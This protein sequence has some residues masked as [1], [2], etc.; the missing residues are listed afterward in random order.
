MARAKLRNP[1]SN[2][3]RTYLDRSRNEGLVLEFRYMAAKENTDQAGV[4]RPKS[5]KFLAMLKSMSDQYETS[6]ES[7]DVWGRMDGIYNYQSTKR[8]YNL[9]WDIP[10]WNFAE[11]R[12]NLR[13]VGLLANFL[14]PAISSKLFT[15]SDQTG[16]L[17][18]AN[19]TD[20]R[21][22]PILTLKYGNLIRDVNTNGGLYGFI[23]GGFS[24]NIKLE[25]GMF[26][27]KPNSES[28]LVSIGPLEGYHFFKD[29]INFYPKMIELNI[30]YRVLHSHKLGWDLESNQSDNQS[31]DFFPYG[32]DRNLVVTASGEGGFTDPLEQSLENQTRSFDADF[33]DASGE[34]NVEQNQSIG[35]GA[36]MQS[37][38]E[39]SALGISEPRYNNIRRGP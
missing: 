7:E 9:T 20:I 8:K 17:F 16:T 15:K 25:Q 18:K 23:D 29:K 10:A 33:Q 35:E 30:S 6:W 4:Q 2:S 22:P 12:D 21:A 13:N 31:V 19:I 11:A 1:V 28:E 26:V 36:S 38:Q 39:D 32:M 37:R 3:D 14:Y 27:E 5:V 34:S 24:V